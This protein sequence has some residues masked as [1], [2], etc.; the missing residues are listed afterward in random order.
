MTDKEKFCRSFEWGIDILWL[1]L[2]GLTPIDENR[3]ARIELCINNSHDHYRGFRV[4]ILNKFEGIVDQKRFWFYDYFE[5][6]KN[7]RSHEVVAY[8]GWKWHC[9]RPSSTRPICEA[10]ERYI[11]VFK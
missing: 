8:C 7:M 10:I 5:K 11:K 6:P 1:D 4:T 3:R 9:E 2:V